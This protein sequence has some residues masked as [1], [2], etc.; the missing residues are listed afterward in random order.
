MSTILPLIVIGSFIFFKPLRR[1]SIFLYLVRILHDRHDMFRRYGSCT[2]PWDRC[3]LL[4]VW[5]LSTFEWGIT[6]AYWLSLFEK[7]CTIQGFFEFYSTLFSFIWT[8]NI[9][10][11]IKIQSK[12]ITPAE[13]I[14]K[15]TIML[16]IGFTFPLIYSLVYCLVLVI[17]LSHFMIT[18]L[19]LYLFPML[20]VLPKEAIKTG[21][22]T[23]YF[24]SFTT[25]L[26][27]KNSINF[28]V[29][30]IFNSFCLFKVYRAY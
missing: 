25:Y 28:S 21:L 4:W 11:S 10:Y 26:W 27:C 16:V 13:K 8:A 1:V 22:K 18:G 3:Y 12:G 15:Q 20:Y 29:I 14:R 7:Q 2:N 24:F 23:S 30:V 9:A 6:S 17:A 5:T 19:H